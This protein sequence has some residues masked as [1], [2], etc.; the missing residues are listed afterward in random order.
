MHQKLTRNTQVDQTGLKEGYTN[1]NCKNSKNK[2]TVDHSLSFQII[3][4]FT[5]LLLTITV[6]GLGGG[7]K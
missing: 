3:K 1:E 4:N 2:Y 7:I 5:V 6:V